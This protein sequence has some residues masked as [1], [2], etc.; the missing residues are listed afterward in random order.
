MPPHR[1]TAPAHPTHTTPPR[2]AAGKLVELEYCAIED[3]RLRGQLRNAGDLEVAVTA[4][5]VAALKRLGP[6]STVLLLDRS[7]SGT[8]RAVAKALAARGFGRVFVIKGGFNGWVASKLRVKS[9]G[10]AFSRVEVVPTLFGTGSTRP[11]T[12]AMPASA[13]GNGRPVSVSGIAPRRALP[14]STGQ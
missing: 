13:R 1:P 11:V 6:G 7:G 12:K 8:A 14:S 10:V 4:L 2:R 5:Q 9:S 3:R